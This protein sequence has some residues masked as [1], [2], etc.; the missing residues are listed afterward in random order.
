MLCLTALLSMEKAQAQF[1]NGNVV[2]LQVGDGSAALTNASTAVFLKEYNTTTPAQASAVSSVTVPTTGAHRLTVSGSATSEGQITLSSDSLKLV[3]AGYDTTA[4]LAAVNGTASAAVARAVDTV[5][6]RGTPGRAAATNTAFSANNIRCVARSN[7]ENYWA[8]GANSGT[9]YMGAGTAGAVQTTVANTRTV[10]ALNGNLYFSTS[11]GTAGIWKITGQ[12]VAAGTAAVLIATPSGSSPYGFAINATETVA[13]VS[14]DRTNGQGGIY[15]WT[16]S[17]SVWSPVDTLKPTAT[18][19]T[20]SVIVN[21]SGTYPSIYAI[22]TDNKLIRWNDSANMAHNITVLATA[23]TNMAFRSVA[24]T[25]KAPPACVTPVL[26][27]AVTHKTC[28][29]NGSVTLNITGG[30]TPAT[31]SWTGPGSFTAATQ[32]ISNLQPGTYTVTATTPG[33]C[34]AMTNAVVA[35]SAVITATVA[36]A[37]PVS[38]CPGTIT[39][40][41]N[42]GTGYNYV[43]LGGASPVSGVASYV[44]SA[45]GSYRVVITAGVNCLDTSD[46]VAVTINPLPDTT[47]VRTYPSNIC[48][49]AFLHIKVP[50]TPG[51]IYAWTLN[52]A[53]IPGASDSVLNLVAGNGSGA[54]INYTIK[55]IITTAAGCKDSSVSSMVI[56]PAP[57]ATITPI[58]P[59]APTCNYNTFQLAATPG[60]GYSYSWLS[61]VPWTPAILPDDTV[62]IP[63]RTG[64]Y[65]YRV[66]VTNTFGCSDTSAA[67]QLIGYPSPTPSVSYSNGILTCNTPAMDTITTYAW[68]LNGTPIT[69]ATS[70]N[71]TPAANGTYIVRATN[72]HGCFAD[73]TYVVSGLSAGQIPATGISIYPNPV[74]QTL[75]VKS[76]RP[77]RA[78]LKD[79]QGRTVSTTE[80]AR[81]ID[82]SGINTGIYTLTL[83]DEQGSFLLTQKLVKT[84]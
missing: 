83:Y 65:R 75:F 33:G 31:F 11:S 68:S 41:A 51:A 28:T 61:D 59:V 47:T 54:P 67:I 56:N 52:G 53:T 63:A 80:N 30:T 34:T 77:V 20:R 46:P 69:G 64:T 42:T 35:D 37:G 48:S 32:N 38:G 25:P 6:Y 19:G 1:T 81:Q 23:G 60:T 45:S 72:N 17:G 74:Q 66:V 50:R 13:Y 15:K 10:L 82:L 4:G 62:T 40:S 55:A 29:A 71:V 49:G 43:W 57:T 26:A 12:P 39:L 18:T 44:P 14:D 79:L 21:W 22:T 5:S 9:Y 24:F 73:A 3:I 2:V 7:G 16:L 8:A 36:P 70:Q 58:G 78:V 84:H 76:P 27:T